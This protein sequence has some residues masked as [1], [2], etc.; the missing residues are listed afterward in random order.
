MSHSDTSKFD[1][2]PFDRITVTDELPSYL[3]DLANPRAI[4]GYDL[5]TDLMLHYSFAELVFLALSSV[6]PDRRAGRGIEVAMMA[7][8]AVPASAADANTAT[9]S[10]V[11][12]AGPASAI[13]AT[14]VATSEVARH[15]VA[16]HR[17]L[18]DWLESG[19]AELP[20]P[21]RSHGAERDDVRRMRSSLEDL[22][23]EVPATASWSAA[24]FATLWAIG[25]KAERQWMA[26]T[27][28]A[29]LP[30]AIAQGF[31]TEL[32]SHEYPNNMPR[33]RY[34]DQRV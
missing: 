16:T 32:D 9:L 4:L 12:D 19:A 15:L 23:D 21:Y 31:A 14:A 6:L 30:V 24:A 25:L 5:P 18:R 13:A 27:V 34:A 17:G 7:L 11:V 3:V 1:Q 10:S 8:S 28:F 26:A 20:E 2:T 22:A 33:Y 29:R